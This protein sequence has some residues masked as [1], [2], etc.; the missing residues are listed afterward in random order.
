M[1]RH[2]CVEVSRGVAG[3][4]AGKRVGE[5]CLRVDVVQVRRFDQRRDDSPV[6]AVIVG[7][8]EQ[9]VLAVERGRADGPLDRVIVQLDPAV[10]E[11]AGQPFPA[12]ERVADRFG[13]RAFAARLRQL[14]AARAGRRRWAGCA[15][16]AW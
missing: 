13:E 7:A 10:L 3:G 6:V 1:P 8:R 11:E 9:G 2:E 15:P 12:G 4:E 16:D 14:G 5:P